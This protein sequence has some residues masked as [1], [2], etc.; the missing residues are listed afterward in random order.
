MSHSHHP[1]ST[2]L[3]QE[4]LAECIL[5][6]HPLLLKSLM[7][8][9][10]CFSLLLDG[11]VANGIIFWTED[12]TGVQDQGDNIMLIALQLVFIAVCSLP[13]FILVGLRS[14]SATLATS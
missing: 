10:D 8:L 6:N 13:F 14:Y 9:G 1:I 3:F 5:G 2:T 11:D 7:D 4:L 12:L